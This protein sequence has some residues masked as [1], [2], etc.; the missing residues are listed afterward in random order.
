M[1]VE[2]RDGATLD[3]ST[4]VTARQT[5]RP[6][7]VTTND[8][9][10]TYATREALKQADEPRRGTTPREDGDDPDHPQVEAEAEP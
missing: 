2:R 10:S 3:A 8:G 1:V 5:S 9:M 7:S 4:N 6:P